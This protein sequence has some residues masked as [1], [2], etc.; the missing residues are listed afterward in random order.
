MTDKLRAEAKQLINEMPD[1]AVA[2]WLR[3]GLRLVNGMPTEKAIA[4]Y[5]RELAVAQARQHQRP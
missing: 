4:L 2:V 5:W 1:W 3:C